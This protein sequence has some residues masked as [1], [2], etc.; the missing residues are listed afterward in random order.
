[1][2]DVDLVSALHATEAVD[3]EWFEER[4]REAAADGADLEAAIERTGAA[5][6]DRSV[7]IDYVPSSVV[8]YRNRSRFAAGIENSERLQSSL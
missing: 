1:M 6:A 4:V 8:Q 3:H 2:A 7:P 5:L